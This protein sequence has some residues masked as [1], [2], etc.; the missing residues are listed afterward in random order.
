MGCTK[1]K[2]IFA[3]ALTTTAMHSRKKS[4][5]CKVLG[6]LT[7]RVIACNIFIRTPFPQVTVIILVSGHVIGIKIILQYI[8]VPFQRVLVLNRYEV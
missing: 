6:L 5:T 8:T 4:H 1:T 7:A 2:T 3:H